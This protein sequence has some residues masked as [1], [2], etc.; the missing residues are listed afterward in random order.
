[1][2]RYGDSIY[3]AEARRRIAELRDDTSRMQV[4]TMPVLRPVVSPALK[5][6]ESFRDCPTCPEMVVVPAGRFTMSSPESEAGRATNEGQQR[7]VSVAGFAAG[8]FA[9]TFEEWDACVAAGGCNGYR[10]ADQGG[11]RGRYPVINVSWNDAKA[12]VAWLARTTGK[13]YRLLSEA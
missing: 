2:Q 11:R 4:A 10:P 3:A 6:G 13:P 9:V 5:V 8:K 1:L 7:Q 12:Y